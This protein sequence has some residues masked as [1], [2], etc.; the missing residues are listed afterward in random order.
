MIL[1]AV[2]WW[3]PTRRRFGYRDKNTAQTRPVWV[4][5][6]SWFALKTK[7]ANALNMGNEQLLVG[8]KNNEG[9]Q[10]TWVSQTL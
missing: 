7:G 1:G 10:V 8:S 2:D 6:S 3:Q 4:S 5:L 9:T